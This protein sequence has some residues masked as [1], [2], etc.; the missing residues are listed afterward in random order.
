MLNRVFWSV[1]A[2]ICM[3][4]AGCP[5]ETPG[6]AGRPASDIRSDSLSAKADMNT[7]VH[8]DE[9]G[10]HTAVLAADIRRD[11]NHLVDEQ[12]LYLRQHAHNPVDWYPWGAEALERAQAEHKL[13]FLSIGYSS[14]HWCHVMEEEVFEQDAI[15]EL[16]NEHFICI[17]VDREERP[18]IDAVYMTAVQLMNGSGGWPLSVFLTP[19]LKPFFGATYVPA[20]QFTQLITSLAETYGDD[21]DRIDDIADELAQTLALD[22]TP[23]GSAKVELVGLA[24]KVMSRAWRWFDDEWGGFGSIQKFPTPP[25]WRFA[26][27]YYRQTGDSDVARRLRLTLDRMGDGGIRDHLGGGFHRYSVERTWTI[28]HFE[29]MLYDNAQLAT[30]YLEAAQVFDSEEYAAIARDT[31]EFLLRDM[32]DPAG[33]FYASYDAD[34]GGEEGTYYVWVPAEFAEVAGPE[35]GHALATLFAAT[36]AGN[37]EGANVLTRRISVDAAARQ[38]GR[39][40]AEMA[41]MYD[42]WRAELV[43]YRSQRTAPGL[44]RKVVTTWNAMAIHALVA[45][46]NH[47]GE[48]RYLDAAV[49]TA[50]FL[51]TNHRSP[52]GEL[53]R[54]STDGTTGSMGI[55]DDYAML[56]QAMLALFSSTGDSQYLAKAV[57]LVEFVTVHFQHADAGF[58]LTPDLT[59]VPLGRQV[60]VHDSV[61]PS[62]NA[63]MLRVLQALHAIT[64]NEDYAAQMNEMLRLY[65]S[66][67]E[68][69]GVEMA[70]WHDVVL[71]HQNPLHTVM[72]AGD[73]AGA[74]AMLAAI[75]RLNAP[76]ALV[77]PL[78][79]A[80]AG[81][82]LLELIPAAVGKQSDDGQA[83]AYVCEYGSCQT[84]TTELSELQRQVLDGW[85]H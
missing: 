8:R 41:G 30:L 62:G 83:V 34:S 25:R 24:D 21:A 52:T 2:V 13:I 57:E 82:E 23:A 81:A 71:L 47:F 16:L 36:E 38:A 42:K 84:P 64:G 58:Y 32:H 15:A 46:F 79:E 69:S 68:T 72:I 20:D 44:D 61:E 22:I 73:D 17:K 51:W 66:V 26:L 7:I 49:Q 75:R 63:M 60:E 39:A 35:D 19:E 12:S 78:P 50:D 9:S 53:Y 40:E 56:A 48:A 59:T 1:I 70:T 45:A 80:G 6:R 76:F 5:V 55:L 33:R 74:G 67:L 31:L 54:T 18:D 27:H 14:C 11:G 37:F 85:L 29:K 28:P 3:V 65:A 43:D 10:M 4:V 77:V